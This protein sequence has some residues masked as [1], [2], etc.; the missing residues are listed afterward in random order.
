[1]QII[2]SSNILH[3]VVY[4]RMTL[5]TFVHA[6]Q[7]NIAGISNKSE[8]ANF[9]HSFPL[10][11]NIRVNESNEP[12]ETCIIDAEMQLCYAIG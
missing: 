8:T 1:M 10:H 7:C 5:K 11:T 3:A 6:I 12:S 2:T 9:A 4:F